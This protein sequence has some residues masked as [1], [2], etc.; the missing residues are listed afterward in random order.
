VKGKLS[1]SAAELE[2]TATKG[3]VRVEA[4]DDIDL[5]GETI[6]LN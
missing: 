5:V 6:H 2:L 3:K 1:I 4:S